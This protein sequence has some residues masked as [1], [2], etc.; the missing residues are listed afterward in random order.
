M[1]D[2]VCRLF[3]DIV[4]GDQAKRYSLVPLAGPDL[5]A[6]FIAGFKVTNR[7]EEPQPVYLVRVRES[8]ALHCT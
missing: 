5:G 4:T 2:R 7:S 8:G 3:L 6:G 1:N